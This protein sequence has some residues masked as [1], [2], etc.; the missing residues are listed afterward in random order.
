MARKT[1]PTRGDELAARLRGG[2]Q[3]LGRVLVPGARD[4]PVVTG[5]T[6]KGLFTDPLENVLA[7]IAQT[8]V[9]SRRVLA[10]DGSVYLEVGEGDQRRLVALADGTVVVPYAYS[11]L[12]N[13]FKVEMSA[14]DREPVQFPPSKQ[15]ASIVLNSEAVR[16]TLPTIRAYA[17]RPTFDADLCLRG[18]G[19]H[20]D[21]GLLVHGPEVEPI[22][23]SEADPGAP[24]LERLPRHLR[25]LL[26]GFCCRSSADVA[27]MVGAM[28]TVPL[29]EQFVTA[30]KPLVL[31]DGNQPGLGKTLLARLLGVLLDGRDPAVLHYTSDDEEL[32]KRL[33][34]LLRD[35]QSLVLIDNA[36][37][38][39]G[40]TISS[41]AIE[42]NSMAPGSPSASWANRRT[43]RGPT[44]FCGH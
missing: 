13:L 20:A 10:R 23:P 19:W 1:A 2:L 17:S 18:P 35:G 38:R 6:P 31:L 8:L 4:L 43:T 37:V 5:V 40:G 12:S 41:V 14:T 29:V 28:V 34:A 44:T 39:G 32:A 30:G 7:S 3:S 11:L 27:N 33:C 25:L 16:G 42:S 9:E 22:L 36:K 15:L 26:S 21:L 24:I